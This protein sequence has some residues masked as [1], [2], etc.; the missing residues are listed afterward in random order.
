MSQDDYQIPIPPSFEAVYRDPRGR[1]TVPLAEFRARYELC[2]DMAQ[3]LVERSQEVHHG[4][5]VSEDIILQRTEDGLASD[6]AGFSAA[7][8]RWVVTRLAELL[9]WPWAHRP[10]PEDAAPESTDEDREH[11]RHPR[12]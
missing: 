3:L 11:R 5:G 7:E 6:G 12:F 1:L 10:M 9:N 4:Q 2:E 8:A